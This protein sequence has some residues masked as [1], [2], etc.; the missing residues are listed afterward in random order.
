MLIDF[1]KFIAVSFVLFSGFFASFILLCH[2]ALS[3]Q[4]TSWLLV[5]VFLGSGALGLDVVATIPSP[6]TT[7]LMLLFIVCSKIL[8]MTVIVCILRDVYVRVIT[9]A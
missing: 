4:Q 8:M 7:P 3:F 5:K 1:A 6:L 2:P 9:I